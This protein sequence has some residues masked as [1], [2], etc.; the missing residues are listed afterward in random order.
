MSLRT[1]VKLLEIAESEVTILSCSHCS[2]GTRIPAVGSCLTC[3]SNLCKAHA[4][5][6]SQ[7]PRNRHHRFV[8]DRVHLGDHEYTEHIGRYDAESRHDY[9]AQAARR[10][11][12]QVLPEWGRQRRE[13][14]RYLLDIVCSLRERQSGFNVAKTAAASLTLLG[15]ALIYAWKNDVDDDGDDFATLLGAVAKGIGAVV[16][17][18]AEIATGVLNIATASEVR[19]ALKEDERLSKELHVCLNQLGEIKPGTVHSITRAVKE[20]EDSCR[21]GTQAYRALQG[22]YAQPPP[23]ELHTPIHESI[24]ALV[25][26]VNELGSGSPSAIAD[27]IEVKINALRGDATTIRDLS[28][29]FQDFD[30]FLE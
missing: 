17:V 4:K 11:L 12:N 19:E 23:R 18:G 27:E 8:A 24:V 26:Q 1:R 22:S 7:D 28:K 29:Q 16:D 10:R 6:H 25:K 5:A 20:V 3:D 15:N 30:Q 9:S 14:I 13:L 21:L 2:Y